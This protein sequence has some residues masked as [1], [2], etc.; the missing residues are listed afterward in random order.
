MA[1]GE[2]SMR[3]HKLL[4]AGIM[5]GLTWTGIVKAEDQPIEQQLV[6]AMN[7][8]F[9]AHPGFRANHAKGIV[10]EG[11]FKAA[12]EA[13]GLSRA[14][15]FNG[16]PIP[17]TVR[18]SDS[19]GIPNIADGSTNANPHGMAIKF[20]LPDG[21]DTD[22]V[23]NSLKFFPVA[24]GCWHWQ[25]VPPTPPSRQNLNSSRRAILPCLRPLPPRV[26]RI[27]LPMKSITV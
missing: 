26:R 3:K 16:S 7:K 14:V 9:G 2:T 10:V 13:A 20:H 23:I 22:M 18:F 15:L 4:I 5:F 11:N 17:A 21:S 24:T 19:T 27:A 1:Q 12:A 6:D 25:Q 8:V